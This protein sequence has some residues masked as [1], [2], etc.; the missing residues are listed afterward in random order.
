MSVRR[1]VTTNDLRCFCL[2]QPLLARYGI[3][4]LGQVYVHVKAWKQREIISEVIVTEGVVNLRCRE[5]T[6][7]HEVKIVGN[8]AKLEE[9]RTPA[10]VANPT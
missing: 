1:A 9:I 4:D 8:R 10:F 6:R 2:R 7:W 5:C 3:N